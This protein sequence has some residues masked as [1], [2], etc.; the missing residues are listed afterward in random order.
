MAFSTDTSNL[1]S[2][3]SRKWLITINNP[4]EHGY[5]HERIQEIMSHGA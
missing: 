5:D 4:A 3:Q 2:V 1:D